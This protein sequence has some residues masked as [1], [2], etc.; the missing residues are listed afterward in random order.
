MC[1]WAK[2][3]GGSGD[4]GGPTRG[5]GGCWSVSREGR[6][7]EMGIRGLSGSVAVADAAGNA[8]C[9]KE[10]KEAGPKSKICKHFYTL[11]S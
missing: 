10:R 7:P 5:L 2:H 1:L 8:S 6:P 9:L 3:D 11:I 4:A